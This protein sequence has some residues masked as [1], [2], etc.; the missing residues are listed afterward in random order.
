MNNEK[1]TNWS[2]VSFT[3]STDDSI[4]VSCCY[5]YISITV[6]PIFSEI[7]SGRSERLSTEKYSSGTFYYLVYTVTKEKK[8]SYHKYRCATN[9]AFVQVMLNYSSNCKI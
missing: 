8:Q 7:V 9:N 3:T 5:D 2:T 1:K 4:N 6:P